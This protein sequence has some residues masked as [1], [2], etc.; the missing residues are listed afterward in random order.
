MKIVTIICE[1]NL[2]HNG[3]LRQIE[4]I[5][6]IFKNDCII[7]SCMSGNWVQRGEPAVL[8]KYLRAQ[9][10]VLCGADLILE[11][12]YPWSCST[13]EFFA[14]AGVSLAE[15]FGSDYICFGS[16]SGNIGYLVSS[17]EKISSD[18]YK[19]AVLEARNKN[20]NNKISD[21]K[22]REEV[23]KKLFNSIYPKSPND[24]LGIEYLRAISKIKNTKINPLVIKRTGNETASA[25]RRHYRSGDFIS[26]ENI[27]P[28]E[29]L[30]F[31]LKHNP[32]EADFHGKIMLYELLQKNHELNDLTQR[33][34]GAGGGSGIKIIKTAREASTYNELI[35]K[36]TS[37]IH[38]T[39]FVRR[40]AMNIVMK[41]TDA[42]LREKPEFTILLAAGKLGKLFLHNFKKANKL[43]NDAVYII[44]KPADFDSGY[45]IKSEIYPQIN[46][47][48]RSDMLYFIAS[49][50]AAADVFKHKPFIL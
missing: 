48:H 18:D 49:G 42:M 14:G 12:P 27:V 31:Y 24:I 15:S 6:R 32:N 9:A 37:K 3:H 23:Y 11:L 21:I 7:I 45:N 5:R 40:T 10:A 13:A 44:T 41:T 38:T 50:Q 20:E 25:S 1:Y 22:L 47:S 30:E 2:F 17:A 16:E 29:A 8:N 46:I 26:L 36:C 4:E 39:A 43:N 34:E 19:N 35:K 33:I 28:G